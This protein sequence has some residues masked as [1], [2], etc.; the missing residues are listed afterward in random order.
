MMALALVAGGMASVGS[1]QAQAALMFM[2]LSDINAPIGGIAGYN[3]TNL[4]SLGGI[5]DFVVTGLPVFP[6]SHFDILSGFV[7]TSTVVGDAN[8][9]GAADPGEIVTS[10]I[11]PGTF[12]VANPGGVIVSGSFAQA[13]LSTSIGS[14][15]VTACRTPSATAPKARSTGWRGGAA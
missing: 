9:N 2:D 11:G 15:S 8:L 6:N 14:S 1:S 3:G 13:T 12:Q 4:V 10:I 5:D 7:V